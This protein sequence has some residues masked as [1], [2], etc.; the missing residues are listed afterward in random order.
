[1]DF[2]QHDYEDRKSR[3]GT[4]HF[5]D[6]DARLV[7][8]YEENGYRRASGGP[9]NDPNSPKVVDPD[10]DGQVSSNSDDLAEPT[11]RYAGLSAADLKAEA[12]KRQLSASGGNDAIVARLEEADAAE[13]AKAD[14]G[15]TPAE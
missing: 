10:G 7:A 9:I 11:S 5:S 14:E 4:K 2:T 1:V 12:K 8:L 13:A 15:S 6:E 3:Q